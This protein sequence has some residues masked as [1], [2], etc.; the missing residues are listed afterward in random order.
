M[1][2]TG[3]TF[4]G[5][6]VGQGNKASHNTITVGG[7]QKQVSLDDL[8]SAIAAARDELVRAAEGSD[9]QTEVRY[10]IHKIE[11]ELAEEKPQGLIVRS[12]WE[13]VV[14]VLGPLAAA[15]ASIAQITELIM[16]VFGGGS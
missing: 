15:S 7:V 6:A 16:K 9:A 2:V 4:I 14:K 5:S 13:Q 1:T 10:E 3:G 11:Q 12:R 8:R